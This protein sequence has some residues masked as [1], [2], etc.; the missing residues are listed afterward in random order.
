MRQKLTAAAVFTLLVSVSASANE[1]EPARLITAYQGGGCAGAQRLIEF[2]SFIGQNVTLASDALD[3]RSWKAL[4]DSVAW[5][6][7][8]WHKAGKKLSLGVPMLPRDGSTTLTEAAAGAHDDVFEHVAKTLI[9][10]GNADAIIRIGWEFNGNWFPWAASRD[11]DNY[12]AL[13]RRIV[14]IFRAAPGG[15]FRFDWCPG[16]AAN[17]IA[18]ERAYPGDDFVDIIGLDVYNEIWNSTPRDPQARWVG[19][20]TGPYGL[21]WQRDF[22]RAHGKLISFPEWGTG[23]RSD[24]HGAGDDPHFIRK[25]AEWMRA[26]PVEYQS[27]WDYKASDYDSKISDGRRPLAAAAF[28]EEFGK[29]K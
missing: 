8:C 29:T 9:A 17:Q 11:P 18:P 16:I 21:R 1:L 15:K 14:T 5:G 2:E 7:N 10:T 25:M 24:G 28:K 6:S 19:Y 12:V 23:D 4:H 13:W 26:N 27:Y 20:E 3:S 22:A